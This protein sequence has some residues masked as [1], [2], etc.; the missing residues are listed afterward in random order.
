MGNRCHVSS[1]TMVTYEEINRIL[2]DF[3]GEHGAEYSEKSPD[4]IF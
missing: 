2:A 3:S 4:S 1:V